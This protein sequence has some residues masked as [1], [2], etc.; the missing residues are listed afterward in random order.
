IICF[1]IKTPI[2]LFFSLT[3]DDSSL[4]EQ[5]TPKL[6]KLIKIVT[7]FLAKCD[8]SDESLSEKQRQD[9]EAVCSS[10]IS[11]LLKLRPAKISVIGYDFTGKSSICEMLQSGSI[12][13]K[14]KE[15]THL[16]KYNTE[17]FGMPILLWDIPDQGDISDNVWR[18]FILGSD[19]VIIVLD[20]TRENVLE[21]KMMVELTDEII[22]Y[23]ELLIIANK[24]DSEEALEPKEI[25][26]I[27][28]CKVFP[29]IANDSKNSNI[30]QK[31]TAKLLEIKAEGID[32]SKDDYIIQRND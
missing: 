7:K 18:S 3:Y 26:K 15:T 32:Y 6:H 27:L 2:P 9:L 12:P 20:S 4:P 23:A 29:F 8:I 10:N 14:Y 28:Q 30:I 5:I 1:K 24:Q 25:E 31:Q 22:P 21:S 17:L 13:R 19:A 16:K 11:D